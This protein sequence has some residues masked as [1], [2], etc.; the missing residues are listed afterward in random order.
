MSSGE[1]IKL[2][3]MGLR[4]VLVRKWK[5]DRERDK[6][7]QRPRSALQF[8]CVIFNL[9]IFER[10]MQPPRQYTIALRINAIWYEQR[11]ELKLNVE[12]ALSNATLQQ[13][14][15]PLQGSG[16]DN[17]KSDKSRWISRVSLS[18]S[19]KKIR[20]KKKKKKK[21]HFQTIN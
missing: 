20:Q 5:R 3:K 8:R 6:Y 14:F 7:I 15:L 18:K 21:I 11:I 1:C 10:V 19:F 17:G 2:V 16:Q 12:I 9:R 13:V 4:L